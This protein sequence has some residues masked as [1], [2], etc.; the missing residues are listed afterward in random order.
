MPLIKQFGAL[1]GNVSLVSDTETQPVPQ[2]QGHEPAPLTCRLGE[3]TLKPTAP[4]G[5]VNIVSTLFLYK[6]FKDTTNS[7]VN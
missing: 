3:S 4:T 7:N 1:P 2:S 5:A 6:H